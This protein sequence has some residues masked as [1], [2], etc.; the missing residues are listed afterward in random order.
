MDW[1]I[2]LSNLKDSAVRDLFWSV[3]SPSPINCNLNT[4]LFFPE[5]LQQEL[6]LDHLDY[7]EALDAN[8]TPL[9]L[10]LELHLNNK[11]LGYIF[12]ALL[13]YFFRTSPHVLV[14][15]ANEQVIVDKQ[16]LGELDF[17]IEYKHNIYHIET[18]VKYYLNAT[19]EEQ[20]N[21]WIGS[22]GN[23]DLKG[24]VDK[25][26][27]KQI[28]VAHH[29]Q[30]SE[31]VGLPYT[32]FLWLKGKFYSN[33]HL[34]DWKNRVSEFGTFMTYNQF[35]KTYREKTT[36]MYFVLD[37][38]AWMS[39]LVLPS[40][41]LVCAWHELKLRIKEQEKNQKALHLGIFEKGSYQTLF[42]ITDKVNQLLRAKQ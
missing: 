32:S 4:D 28:P 38:P 9:H 13:F 36:Q 10:F 24:K 17:I 12:E 37:R 33:K 18:S 41:K 25:V 39:D 7:F 11:R 29:P 31:K 40:Q 16:T 1:K 15:M 20:F 34:P 26:L 22:S 3:A 23:D 42:L 5:D 2:F 14:L 30:I 8:P 6:V 35:L 19:K 27:N 21:Y